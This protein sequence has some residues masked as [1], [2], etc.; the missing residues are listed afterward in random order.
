MKKTLLSTLV[1]LTLHFSLHAQLSKG[2]WLVGGSVGFTSSTTNEPYEQYTATS[3]SI[4]PKAGYFLIDRLA[5]GLTLGTSFNHQHYDNSN[6]IPNSYTDNIYGVGPFL[7]YYFLPAQKPANILLE[8]GDQY[9]WISATG[10]NATP[11]LNSFGFAAGPA[12]FLNPS[13]A[14]ECT[15]GYTWN[16]GGGES[17]PPTTHVFKTAIGLQVHLPGKARK[18]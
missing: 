7:R 3:I 9:E 1:V 8:V 13:V 10:L 6:I 5:A 12:F 11:H 4:A 15:I 16:N 2:S 18:G 14:L 17:A